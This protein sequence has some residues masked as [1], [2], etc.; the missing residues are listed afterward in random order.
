MRILHAQQL[1][2]KEKR[3]IDFLFGVLRHLGL[4]C[5]HSYVSAGT[6]AAVMV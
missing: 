6:L 4:R 1:I 5:T 3:L 2:I